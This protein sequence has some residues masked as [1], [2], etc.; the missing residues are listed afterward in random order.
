[1]CRRLRRQ[2]NKKPK[3][4]SKAQVRPLTVQPESSDSDLTD[5]EGPGIVACVAQPQWQ[6]VAKGKSIVAA[7]VGR[8][9][10]DHRPVRPETYWSPIDPS[11]N[12]LKGTKVT[13]RNE[14][15]IGVRRN[16]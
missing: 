7:T 11:I 3:P 2:Q 15:E 16:H 5:D 12:P 8:R 14:K 10:D 13:V 4:K 1:M 9:F 6:T